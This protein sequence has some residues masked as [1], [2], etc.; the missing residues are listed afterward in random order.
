MGTSV[1]GVLGLSGHGVPGGARESIT[2]AWMWR[3][4]AEHNQSGMCVHN[5]E[6]RVG[7]DFFNSSSH[8][9]T[10]HTNRRLY[11]A[12][13]ALAPSFASFFASSSASAAASALYVKTIE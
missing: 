6:C 4:I 3:Q 11:R 10:T 13:Y 8:I 9:N 5:F 12:L 1:G 7:R 2:G